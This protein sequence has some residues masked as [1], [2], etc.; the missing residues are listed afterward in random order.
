MAT[1]KSAE[2][3]F[4]LSDILNIRAERACV[5]VSVPAGMFNKEKA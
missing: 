1:G 4:Y 5:L 3:D 2:A